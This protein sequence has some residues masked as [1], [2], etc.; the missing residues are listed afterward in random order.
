MWARTLV[1]RAGERR[2]QLLIALQGRRHGLLG[3]Q[4]T[5][6]LDELALRPVEN[7]EDAQG[8]QDRAA[9]HDEGGEDVG[10]VVRDAGV[11]QGVAG[12]LERPDQ[13]DREEDAH[14]FRPHEQP[15]VAFRVHLPTVLRLTGPDGRADRPY[16]CVRIG[17]YTHGR[18]ER[19]ARRRHARRRNPAR[20]T[21]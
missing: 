10:G 11:D 3:G 17:S 16:A 12:Q 18:R 8:E 21:P 13:A 1:E 20:I 9:A 19:G 4:V 6:G 15:D 7:R 5:V 14:P 2:G